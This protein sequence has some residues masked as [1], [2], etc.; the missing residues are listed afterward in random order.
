MEVQCH[1]QTS[2][3]KVE[4]SLCPRNPI[5]ADACFK[6]GYIDAWG[7]GTLKI[8][9]AC[10]EAGL[11]DPE[12]QEKDGGIQV[13]LFKQ[14]GGTMGG[15]KSGTMGGQIGGQAGGQAGGQIGN[16]TE[17]Q[18]AVFELIVANPRISRKELAKKLG[19]NESAVQKHT[20]ALK[21]KKMIEREGE[22]TGMWIIIGME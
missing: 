2:K 12:I 1:P 22:T 14:E 20:D 7:R 6:S 4:H 8:I 3:C 19:I 11:P 18:K 16:L 15:T 21:K 17:R 9:E 13:T 5:L 10:K